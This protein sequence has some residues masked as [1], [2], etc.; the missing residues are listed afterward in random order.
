MMAQVAWQIWGSM[1]TGAGGRMGGAG[2]SPGVWHRQIS[3]PPLARHLWHTRLLTAACTA[4]HVCT[5][6]HAGTPLAPP[7]TRAA[8]RA[9]APLPA[10]HL[11]PVP[12][13][14]RV[15]ADLLQH[16]QHPHLLFGLTLVGLGEDDVVEGGVGTHAGVLGAGGALGGPRFAVRVVQDLDE[17]GQAAR[18]AHGQ[19]ALLRAGHGQQRAGHVV[20]VPRGQHGQEPE[21]HL[22]LRDGDSGLRTTTPHPAQPTPAALRR[23]CPSPC[24]CPGCCPPPRG[25]SGGPGCRPPPCPAPSRRAAETGGRRGWVAT[26]RSRSPCPPVPLFSGAHWCHE[27]RQRFPVFA[28]V[29]FVNAR[30]VF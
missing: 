8:V 10:L 16:V 6:T 19:A 15:G 17:Q 21:D 3:P 7:R 18:L 27:I 4:T 23:G 1:G 22:H 26:R 20:L 5:H 14:L 12:A 13:G 25:G 11:Q 28:I 29:A 30:V 24:C 2:V 9:S